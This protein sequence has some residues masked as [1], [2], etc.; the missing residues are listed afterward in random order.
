MQ[1]A[2][3]AAYGGRNIYVFRL[4]LENAALRPSSQS[5]L[6]DG[7]ELAAI[8]LNEGK[9]FRALCRKFRPCSP[10]MCCGRIRF[11]TK[12][13]ESEPVFRSLTGYAIR[14]PTVL[15]YWHYTGVKLI[16]GSKVQCLFSFL[17]RATEGEKREGSANMKTKNTKPL[18]PV[19]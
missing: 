16:L 17:N 12:N 3:Y 13:F 9:H 11:C 6:K 14:S 2:L 19:L 10:K 15:D 4:L 18:S 5:Q 1:S 8:G 7:G